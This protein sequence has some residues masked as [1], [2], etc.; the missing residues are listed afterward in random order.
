LRAGWALAALLAVL[1]PPLAA[2]D[3]KAVE[4]VP[5][6]LTAISLDQLSQIR[7]TSVAKKQQTLARAAAAVFVVSADD[8]RRSG[9][10]SIPEAL[11]LVPGLHVARIDASKWVVSARG[12]S[13]RL[14]NKL[15]VLVDG[16]SIY[17]PLFSGVLWEM[18]D[19]VME[20]IDR[21]EVIRGPGATVWGANAVNGVINVITKRS[22]DTQGGF[23][24]VGGGSRD[25]AVTTVRQG[26]VIGEG[27]YRIY[28]KLQ[29][30]PRSPEDTITPFRADD[31]WTSG[32]GGF[33]FE[34]QMSDR[35]DLEVQGEIN[36]MGGMQ[37]SFRASLAEASNVVENAGI[38][39]TSSFLL[40]RWRH[41]RSERSELSV[42]GYYDATDRTDEGTVQTS[43]K[44]ADVELQHRFSHSGRAELTWGL[45][46]RSVWA[47]LRGTES[48]RPTKPQCRVQYSTAFLQEE[49]ELMPDELILTLGTKVEETTLGGFTIQPSARAIWMPSTKLSLWGAAARA[50][51]AP[52]L[53]EQ[54]VRFEVTASSIL[55]TPTLVSLLPNPQLRNEFVTAFEGGLRL[56]PS[57]HW[58]FDLA[59]FRNQ[60][61]DAFILDADQVRLEAGP[62][63]AHLLI[64]FRFGNNSKIRSYGFEVF[65]RWRPVDSW[66]L[67]GSY[68]RLNIREIDPGRAEYV[69]SLIHQSSPR[70]LASLRSSWNLPG[71]IEIDLSAQ[72]VGATVATGFLRRGEMFPSFLRPDARIEWKANDRTRL[73]FGVQNAIDGDRYEFDAESL[74]VASK[75]GRN[76]YGK[77]AWAF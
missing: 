70:N 8:I 31:S 7:V 74:S 41:A 38:A 61:D 15:L 72:F 46:F 12:F 35:D 22:A 27:H 23:A 21:I 5:E 60:Y 33:R 54:S 49:I 26:G 13:G 28:G 14:S 66:R 10:T 53:G 34:T 39:G 29:G 47:D 71:R 11:R 6:D 67:V 36:R 43:V 77:L 30:R 4:P 50:A 3:A 37:R 55:G 63:P 19:I 18:H 69:E 57:R 68:S 32:R 24:S 76:V 51:R 73:S 75:A 44:T 17:T 40:G 56:E 59:V 48:L 25:G 16:R 2:A 9:A 65:A 45:G 42:Q 62:A 64:P 1:A 52:S 20:D 58:D